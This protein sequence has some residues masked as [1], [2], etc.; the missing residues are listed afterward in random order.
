MEFTKATIAALSIPVGKTD[1]IQFDDE[2]PGFGIR[3]RAGG[4][5]CWIIQYRV[6]GRQR[7]V[8]IGDARKVDLKAARA[9]AGRRFAEIILGRDPQAEKAAAKAKAA[10]RMGPLADQYL[11]LK[12]GKVRKN[13]II[14][15]KRYLTRY[16]KPLRSSSIEAITRRAIAARLNE[17]VLEY[18]ATAAA[19]ARQSL[20][21]FFT[22]LIREGI[23]KAN[24]VIGTND[25]ASHIDARDRVLTDAELRAIWTACR[26]DDFGRIVRLLMLTGCRRDEIGGL[27]WSELDLDRGLLSIPGERT[28]N[29]HAL[30]LTLPAKAVSI[31]RDAPEREGR[32]YLFGER[33]GAYS[34]WSYSSLT[35]NSR[36]AEAQGA[37]AAAWRLHDLRRTAATRMAEIGVAPH[38][39][40]AILNHRGGHKA[41]VAGIYNRATYEIEIK[42]ALAVWADHLLSIVEGASPKIVAMPTAAA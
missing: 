22:W 2:L 38:V 31:L 15:D 41:G 3:L 5:R 9:E 18:G 37:P 40:E 13:T 24:P 27:K 23:A 12:E 16:W 6:A 34:A 7:R 36:I 28:K 17:I 39:I 33:G 11:A 42:R 21:A 4:K 35:L 26:D 14:A 29:H 32:D 1:L 8:T 10:V 19:R 25:P 20:S 30:Q